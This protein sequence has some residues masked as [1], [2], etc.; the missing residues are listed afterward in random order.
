MRFD[1]NKCRTSVL[2]LFQS[3]KEH[4]VEDEVVDYVSSLFAS[5]DDDSEIE[6]IIDTLRGLSDK[7]AAMSEED[8]FQLISQLIASLASHERSHGDIESTTSV[9]VQKEMATNLCASEFSKCTEQAVP[10]AQ[11]WE[12]ISS[13]FP[14]DV[15]SW[16][17]LSVQHLQRSVLGLPVT[18]SEVSVPD[19]QR[20]SLNTDNFFPT[21]RCCSRL[22]LRAWA[23]S[24]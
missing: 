4:N 12:N 23:E 15:R 9:H 7:F 3:I 14:V 2:A 17:M 10:G 13:N 5:I 22:V 18:V 21:P 19:N 1:T 6:D 20:T 24:F 8:Q 11:E 16:G